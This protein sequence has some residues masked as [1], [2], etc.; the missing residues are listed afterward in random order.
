[1]A[2][3][4]DQLL[5]SGLVDKNRANKANKEKQKQTRHNRKTGGK[6]VN[7]ARLAAQQGQLQKAAHDR[8]LNRQRQHQSEQKAVMAQI[9]Q[10]IQLNQIECD[11]GKVD[12]SFVHENKVKRLQIDAQLQQQLSQGRLA[13]V[14]FKQDSRRCYALIPAIVAEKIA[15]RDAGSVVQLNVSDGEV[16]EDDIYAEYKIPDNLMW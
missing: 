7:Q 11:N 1:M 5:K 14:W 2:S 16:D 4:Q 15:Q 9:R 3:L 10:L 13:I 6:T 8:E 12:Y